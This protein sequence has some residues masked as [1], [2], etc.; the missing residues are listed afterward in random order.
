L[1][2]KKWNRAVSNDRIEKAKKAFEEKKIKVS[3]VGNKQDALKALIG[4]IPDGASIM[5]AGSTTL[6]EIG[7]TEYAKHATQ[8]NNLHA[9]ILAEKDQAKA[10]KLRNEAMLADYFLS[11]VSAI[12]EA[13]DLLACDFTGTRVGAFAQAAGHL[14]LVV[15]SQKIVPTLEDAFQR[16]AE[17][18]LPLESARSRVVYKV[19]GSAI[20]HV[21]VISGPNPWGIPDRINV[22]IVK[23]TLGF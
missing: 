15:G 7:F 23:E 17:Y 4:L 16:Q 9:K 22:I 18:C 6:Q 1:T 19:P 10:S 3:V 21:A 5:N 13:G 8:W 11:S 2:K 20:N 14:V 12:T